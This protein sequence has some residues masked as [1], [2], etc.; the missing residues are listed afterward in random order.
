[1]WMVTL[2]V[3]GEALNSPTTHETLAELLRGFGIC[4]VTVGQHGQRYV[5][6]V[7]IGGDDAVDAERNAM[8]MWRYAVD[9]I[10]DRDGDDDG[11]V[12]F[13]ASAAA[14]SH[15]LAALR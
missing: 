2:E 15:A 1:M 13:G 5:A 7:C 8:A 9:R 10:A 4:H 3:Q 14:R 6:Q 11:P 12:R